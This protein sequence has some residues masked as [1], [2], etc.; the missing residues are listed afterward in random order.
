APRLHSN[1]NVFEAP[2]L[3]AGGSPKFHWCSVL[4]GS[5]KTGTITQF[6][7]VD[8]STVKHGEAPT[9]P[10]GQQLQMRQVTHWNFGKET[11]VVVGAVQLAEVKAAMAG[12]TS[13]ASLMH[14][15]KPMMVI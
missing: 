11:V 9:L 8:A 4:Y 13:V 3:L 2:P 15:Q 7:L 10:N 6:L 1:G 14:S 12:A 5:A